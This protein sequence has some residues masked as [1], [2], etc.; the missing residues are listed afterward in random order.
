M[1]MI[2]QRFYNFSHWRITEAAINGIVIIQ[3]GPSFSHP[4]LDYSHNF[5]W[6]GTDLHFHNL[7]VQDKMKWL[8]IEF[9]PEMVSDYRGTDNN[10]FEYWHQ[11]DHASMLHLKLSSLSNLMPFTVKN[12]F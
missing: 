7:S 3:P 5:I 11:L 6:T 12:L 1:S 10:G 8:V 2:R 9:L 4:I